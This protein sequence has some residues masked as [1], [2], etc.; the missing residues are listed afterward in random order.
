MKIKT[1][2]ELELQWD[3]NY[4]VSVFVWSVPVAIGMVAKDQG[5]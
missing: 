5:C 1:S 3:M 4:S 2:R